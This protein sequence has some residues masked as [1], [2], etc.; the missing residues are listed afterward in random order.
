MPHNW[1]N[2][3]TP[4]NCRPV[5]HTAIS[6]ET[7]NLFNSPYN[8]PKLSF[9]KPNVSYAFLRWN[10]DL[11]L[12]GL[13]FPF[14]RGIPHLSIVILN[15][16]IGSTYVTP[17]K[18]LFHLL[19]LI[20]MSNIVCYRMLCCQCLSCLYLQNFKLMLARSAMERAKRDD[21]VWIDWAKRNQERGPN[22]I[23]PLLGGAWRNEAKLW[24]KWINEV[25]WRNLWSPQC[26][27]FNDIFI[28][29]IYYLYILLYFSFGS[30]LLL[31]LKYPIL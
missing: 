21:G 8:I 28:I 19:H 24:T 17:I 25:Q 20:A 26:N 11:L 14:W 13:S 10:L 27:P 29:Y 15:P 31:T 3:E 9:P 7:W 2:P 6:R 4:G 1:V 5:A 12:L 16:F 30:F 23:A 18:G 22:V